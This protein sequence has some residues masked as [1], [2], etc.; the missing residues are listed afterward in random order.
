MLLVSLMSNLN[1]VSV[2]VFHVA[3]VAGGADANI[4]F[5]MTLFDGYVRCCRGS[6]L[7]SLLMTLMFLVGHAGVGVAG[8]ADF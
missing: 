8:Q 4:S 1:A 7:P 6:L 3:A 2:V 5:D